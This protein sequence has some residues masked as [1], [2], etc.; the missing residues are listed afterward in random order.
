MRNG[1][2]FSAFKIG[3]FVLV[4]VSVLLFCALTN[5]PAVGADQPD[6]AST[7]PA[8]AFLGTWSG[9]WENTYLAQFTI[10]HG[11]G[12]QLAV[13]YEW[14]YDITQPL[15]RQKLTPTP[16]GNVLRMP[17]ASI[18]FELS[19]TDP[20]MATAVGNFTDGPRH[21]NLVRGKNTA[22]AKGDCDHPAAATMPII[23]DVKAI[24]AGSDVLNIGPDGAAWKHKAGE[25]PKDI[26]VNGTLWDTDEKPIRN[27]I[28]LNDADLSTATVI[29][30]T[31][32]ETLGM[33]R[34]KSGISVFFGDTTKIA[35]PYEI[36]I[37]FARKIPAAPASKTLSSSNTIILDVSAEIDGSD[38]LTITPEG[39]RWRHKIWGW[40]SDVMFNDVAWDVKANPLLTNTGLANADLATATVVARRGRDLV[41]MEKTDNGITIYFSD[42]MDS[43]APYDIKIAFAPKH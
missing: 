29:S 4:P 19:A 9:Y 16:D 8:D 30:R 1:N 13:L 39:A 7:Q 22:D 12:R 3:L 42:F 18:T 32:R 41:A 23:L 11:Q 28:G 6:A 17:R 26:M 40:P 34:T 37:G 5:V 24:I 14:E 35:T 27:D 20:N 2:F 21:I 31:G 15:H 36:Q 38:V 33:E 25:F 10:T 43:D